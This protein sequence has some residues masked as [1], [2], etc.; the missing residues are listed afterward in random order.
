M[1]PAQVQNPT[2]QA[3]P[4]SSMIRPAEGPAQSPQQQAMGMDVS[5]TGGDNATPI[6]SSAQEPSSP[7]PLPPSD[8]PPP[9]PPLPPANSS[10]NQIQNQHVSQFGG[11]PTSVAGHSVLMR[12][13]TSDVSTSSPSSF[14]TPLVTSSGGEVIKV[15]DQDEEEGEASAREEQKSKKR[16]A[17]PSPEAQANESG[18][19]AIRQDQLNHPTAIN[20]PPQARIK[21][22]QLPAWLD[23]SNP[24][25]IVT[26]PATFTRGGAED[27]K[28]ATGTLIRP[29]ET[30]GGGQMMLTKRDRNAL[31][32]QVA[33]AGP[34][35]ETNPSGR[36]GSTRISDWLEG[37]EQGKRTPTDALGR[38]I[39]AKVPT[40]ATTVTPLGLQD[41]LPDYMPIDDVPMDS[42]LPTT[43]AANHPTAIPDRFYF[44]TNFDGT[45]P[46][47]ILT[48]PSSSTSN[49][50]GDYSFCGYPPL[51]QVIKDKQQN[52]PDATW[53]YYRSIHNK[54]GDITG[55]RMWSELKKKWTRDMKKVAKGGTM[56]EKLQNMRARADGGE[57]KRSSKRRKL[58]KDAESGKDGD[59]SMDIVNSTDDD[60]QNH[61]K[62]SDSASK[63]T[64]SGLSSRMSHIIRHGELLLEA[65]DSTA[66]LAGHEWERKLIKEKKISSKV[67]GVLQEI[68]DLRKEYRAEDKHVHIL[69]FG[70]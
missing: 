70:E 6:V 47:V 49:S 25:P 7:H 31:A 36:N 69:I 68:E 38:P 54:L 63:P 22:S 58:D 46:L 18:G 33:G 17:S 23:I 8:L 40:A 20:S 66:T 32:S 28:L 2:T 44:G 64:D 13:A 55:Y 3:V 37:L 62:N 5:Q 65:A 39:P 48:S 1:R 27:G 35:M 12:A 26:N 11:L 29:A 41:P 61:S 59:S 9:P 10:V 14:V 21:V 45:C 34:R 57:I 16:K 56:E 24:R 50:R 43:V 42:P 53:E 15:E 67:V 30:D 19:S 60:N 52:V 51:D 4:S